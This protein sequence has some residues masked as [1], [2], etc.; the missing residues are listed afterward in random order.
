MGVDG[1]ANPYGLTP[2]QVERIRKLAAG[3][4]A[5][6]GGATADAKRDPV[7]T[8]ESLLQAQ[9]KGNGILQIIADK[10]GGPT[11][12]PAVPDAGRVGVPASH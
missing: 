12:G 7:P 8:L 2:D 5:P 6:P 4:S 9:L 10:S 11:P 3:A 1:G